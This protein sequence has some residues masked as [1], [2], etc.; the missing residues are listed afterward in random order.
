MFLNCYQI[1]ARLNL[2]LV[3][4]LGD[5]DSL[6]RAGT[7]LKY[8]NRTV[9]PASLDIHLGPLVLV[10]EA[11]VGHRVISYRNRE[12]LA[13]REVDLRQGPLVLRP[14]QF[15]LAAT[16]ERL[17]M[18]NDLTCLL[19]IKSSMGRIGF[20][21][22]DAGWVDPGFEGA[23]TLEYKN[24]TE[25][26]SIELQWGDPIG[27]LCFAPVEF[28]WEVDSYKTVGRY[29]GHDTVEQIK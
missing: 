29:G 16:I 24:L 4:N 26:H 23:L 22:L 13:M 6:A 2:G 25:H 11:P 28:V 7:I 3:S 27:Q 20:E 19:R 15:I 14:G 9:N 8:A 1:H 21:H 17:A 10:E 18:P 12:R 5:L